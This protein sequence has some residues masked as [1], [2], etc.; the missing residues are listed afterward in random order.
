MECDP[1]GNPLSES[2]TY[3]D[4]PYPCRMT[5]PHYHSLIFCRC[6]F[7][8]ASAKTCPTIICPYRDDR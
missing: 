5:L 4:C 3:D 6:G 7:L 1:L 8:V 2:V